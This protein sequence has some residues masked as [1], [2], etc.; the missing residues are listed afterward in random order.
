M[1]ITELPHG[2]NDEGVFKITSEIVEV[3]KQGF[4]WGLDETLDQRVERLKR[5]F[6]E[7]YGIK[8]PKG[9]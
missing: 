2:G 5:E 1:R 8:A 4:K 6:E 7:K 3:L 9:L